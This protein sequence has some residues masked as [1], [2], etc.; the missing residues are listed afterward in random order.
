MMNPWPAVSDST[1][2]QGT[3]QPVEEAQRAG[4]ASMEAAV[5]AR[6]ED[7]EGDS[8]GVC[9]VPQSS[10]HNLVGSPK[11]L[12]KLPCPQSPPPTLWSF[13]GLSP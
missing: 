13:P 11:R 1:R 3:S 8:E 6:Q 10:P 5:R 2:I 9:P 7:K 12:H 4:E